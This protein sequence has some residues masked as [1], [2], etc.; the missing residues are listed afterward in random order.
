VLAAT[1]PKGMKFD[2]AAS[3]AV[4]TGLAPPLLSRFDCVLVLVD[5]KDPDQDRVMST[6]MISSHCGD[7]PAD[8][9]GTHRAASRVRAATHAAGE[10][11]S[12]RTRRDSG[13]GQDALRR[14]ETASGAGD[15]DGGVSDSAGY[16]S[17]GD[18]GGARSAT[19]LWPFERV[20]R[21]IALVR[22]AFDPTLTPEAE[23]LIRGY[24]QMRRR[25]E[26]H[27]LGRPTIRLLESLI[28]M[29]QAHAR[30]MW[31]TEAGRTDVVVAVDLVEASSGRSTECCDNDADDPETRVQQQ[32]LR[33]IRRI[34]AE[35]GTEWFT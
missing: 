11:A 30:L 32:E 19:A 12:K 15:R 6:H 14:M 17:D 31:R 22:C 26:D 9:A 2:P 29:T 18:N 28:R 10:T 23:S 3:L 7:R 33:L 5:E 20:R 27:S 21:Y 34:T 13:F 35:L 25:S 8:G 24:Y 4:N 1:N 16:D